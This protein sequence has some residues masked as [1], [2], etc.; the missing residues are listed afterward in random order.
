MNPMDGFKN[1]APGDEIRFRRGR[2]GDFLMTPFQ[3]EWCHFRNIKQRDVAPTNQ[4]DQR[5]LKDVRQA[6]M[7]AFWSR[8]PATVRANLTQVKRMEELGKL[9]YGFYSVSPE[10]GP[11][12]LQD[13][14]GM[15]PAVVLL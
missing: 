14:F 10:L 4:V 3:C 2:D 6:N 9:W 5:L 7:D 12:S 13:T 8:E 11:F 15:K 1:L